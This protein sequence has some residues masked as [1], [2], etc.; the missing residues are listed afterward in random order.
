MKFLVCAC[1]RHPKHTRHAAAGAGAGGRTRGALD[2]PWPKSPLATARAPHTQQGQHSFLG[3]LGPE[4]W[5]R[6]LDGPVP[7]QSRPQPFGSSSPRWS[8]Q[9]WGGARIPGAVPP[10]SSREG[11]CNQQGIMAYGSPKPNRLVVCLTRH[12]RTALG[13]GE[14]NHPG[15]CLRRTLLGFGECSAHHEPHIDTDLLVVLAVRLR[16]QSQIRGWA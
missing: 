9:P 15:Q 13:A 10:A 2:L 6:A 16:Q 8:P 4:A 14:T 11:R 1:A 12:R 7:A 5:A 3:G